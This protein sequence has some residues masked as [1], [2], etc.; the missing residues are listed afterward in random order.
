[1]G[2]G[3]PVEARRL[4]NDAVDL[5]KVNRISDVEGAVRLDRVDCDT[6]HVSEALLAAR[7]TV[8]VARADLGGGREEVL[9]VLKVAGGELRERHVRA[10]DFNETKV[11]ARRG[12]VKVGLR[13]AG[14]V[15]EKV[16]FVETA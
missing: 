9:W 11:T 3:V 5:I 16:R 15:V 4:I 12:D 14:S 1:M 8:R 2:G 13:V 7:N 6:E 10:V